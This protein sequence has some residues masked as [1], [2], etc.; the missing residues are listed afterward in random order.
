MRYR[1]FPVA[2]VL[3]TGTMGWGQTNAVSAVCASCHWAIYNAYR[4][5]PMARSARKLDAAS[6]AE[7]S[8]SASFRHPSSGFA[9]RVSIRNGE[10]LLQF[11]N[12]RGGVRGE[13]PLAYAV[14][15]GVRAFSYLIADDGFLYEAPVAYYA[16]AGNFGKCAEVTLRETPPCAISLTAAVWRRWPH[17][18]VSGCRAR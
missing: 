18:S 4:A 16:A 1:W 7:S 3:L 6:S 2:I 15:S 14:G 12:G 17:G 8:A 11:D 10:Y 13:K 5:T 9:Y